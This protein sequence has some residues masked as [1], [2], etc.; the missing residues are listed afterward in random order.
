[1]LAFSADTRRSDL[2]RMADRHLDVLVIG[3]GI[4]GCGIALD[5]ASGG[6]SV[7]LVE[8]NDFAS[9]TSGRSSRMIHGGSVIFERSSG[10]VETAPSGNAARRP[11]SR[12]VRSTLLPGIDSG[13]RS[14]H[15]RDLLV[16][17]GGERSPVA[18]RESV[19]WNRVADLQ[20]HPSGVE[21]G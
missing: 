8:K 14:Q 16:S 9:G 12:P 2:E 13:S 7:G 5:A 1:M 18:Q 17:R 19:G 3:G 11:P 10:S 6:L 15:A 4:T 21:G 20:S